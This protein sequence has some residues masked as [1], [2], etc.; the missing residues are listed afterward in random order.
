MATTTTVI[1]Y[2]GF[3]GQCDANRIGSICV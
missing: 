2:H 1:T 3:L